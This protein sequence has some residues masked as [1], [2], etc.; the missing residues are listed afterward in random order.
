MTGQVTRA[1]KLTVFVALCLVLAA[2]VAS[3]QAAAAPPQP[4]LDQVVA[5]TN[6]ARADNGLPPLTANPLL[7][8]AA[9]KQAEAMAADAFFD[10]T[11]PKTGTQPGD[12]V[13][14]EG[15]RWSVVAENI[16]AGDATP[17]DVVAGWLN[18]PGHRA[19]ILNSDVREIGVGYFFKP[20]DTFPGPTG[21]GH[22]WVQ[23]FAASQDGAAAAPGTAAPGLA[24][25]DAAAAWQALCP[26]SVDSRG[27]PTWNGNPV[28]LRAL[29]GVGRAAVSPTV[30]IPVIV[31]LR[32]RAASL[33]PTTS[34][35]STSTPKRGPRRSSRPV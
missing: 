9:Q 34:L 7:A 25:P 3:A 14:A 24:S 10:H 4:F 22:Y 19:N 2:T 33:T 32:R 29:S 1:A 35:F 20:N 12:R 27:H 21:Y 16:A 11:N 18:S 30:G 23:V 31:R 6:Q 17:A 13:T 28:I 8:A 26:K 5:L 15:Y